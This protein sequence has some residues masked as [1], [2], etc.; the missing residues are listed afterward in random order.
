MFRDG[1]PASP[2]PSDPAYEELS[3]LR[4]AERAIRAG[5]PLLALGLLR[6]L[7]ERFPNGRLKEERTAARTM[8]RCQRALD[9]EARS[10]AAAFDARYPHSVYGERVRALCKKDDDE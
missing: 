5:E 3:M 10:Q 8:A 9:A 2:Q 4:R 6:E 7:D 1:Q